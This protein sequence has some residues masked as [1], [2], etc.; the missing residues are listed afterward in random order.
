MNPVPP[1]TRTFRLEN[2]SE[3]DD[4]FDVIFL[5]NKRPA[6]DFFDEKKENVCIRTN[7]RIEQTSNI[8]IDLDISE[9]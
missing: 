7:I 8:R 4:T 6:K 9:K 5:T 3:I 2:Q 1:V